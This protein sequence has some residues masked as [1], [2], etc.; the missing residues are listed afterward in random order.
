MDKIHLNTS[1][2]IWPVYNSSGQ[3]RIKN[4]KKQLNNLKEPHLFNGRNLI[5]C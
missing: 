3:M 2:Q 4:L 5:I 1:M